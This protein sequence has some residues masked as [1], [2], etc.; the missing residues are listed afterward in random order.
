ML[1]F[2]FSAKTTLSLLLSPWAPREWS[3][4]GCLIAVPGGSSAVP[5]PG[6]SCPDP[7]FTPSPPKVLPAP[8]SCSSTTEAQQVCQAGVS[9]PPRLAQ[10][11]GSPR[12]QGVPAPVTSTFGDKS[13][14][15]SPSIPPVWEAESPYT[16]LLSWRFYYHNSF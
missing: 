3:S 7:Q 10:V 8:W 9:H 6:A 16:K 2:L 11:M 15:Q 1:I 4:R 14:H 5:I 12:A 13:S